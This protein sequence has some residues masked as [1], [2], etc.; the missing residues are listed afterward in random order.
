M[1][2]VFLS[3]GILVFLSGCGMKNPFA[4]TTSLTYYGTSYDGSGIED[5]NMNEDVGYGEEN[6]SPILQRATMKP[7]CVRGKWYYPIAVNEGDTF[8]GNASWYGPDFHGRLTASGER[9]NMYALTAASKTLPLNTYVRVTNL[10]NGKEVIVRINDRGPFVESRI[11]D[12]SY[13]AARRL[14]VIKNGVIPVRLEVVSS[15][16]HAKKYAHVRK[17]IKY[18]VKRAVK[19]KEL[20]SYFVQLASISKKKRALEL[21][22]RYQLLN[23][24]YKPYLVA[25]NNR[26][27]LLIGKFKTASQAREFI[28]K[29]GFRGA[30]VVRN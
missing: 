18:P 26:Y 19:N 29:N 12:L 9:Y 3:V 21:Q 27:K 5:E 23:R 6:D 2:K 8:R 17:E 25:K 4:R 22:K 16:E 11:I 20:S 7:Y 14:G 30:F 1:I 13:T 24:K 15:S 28:A 10:N